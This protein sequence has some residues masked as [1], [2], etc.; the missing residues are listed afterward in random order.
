MPPAPNGARPR[1]RFRTGVDSWGLSDEAFCAAR[2]DEGVEVATGSLG[3]RMQVEIVND[4][5]VTI[6][7]DV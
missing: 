2:R 3:A 6:V 7:L 5:P 4:G 1:G